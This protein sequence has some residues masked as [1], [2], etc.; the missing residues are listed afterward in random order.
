[1]TT[2]L[3]RD[4]WST[5]RAGRSLPPGK[6]RYLLYRRLGGPQGRGRQVRKISPPP[7][8]DP[9]T[10]QPAASR[11]NDYWP[12]QYHILNYEYLGPSQWVANSLK[13]PGHV[14]ACRNVNRE[15]ISIIRINRSMKCLKIII[16]LSWTCTHY[17]GVHFTPNSNSSGWKL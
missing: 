7:G 13:A 5:S 3:E 4:E 10:V 8:F 14:I 16:M 17:M 12:W 15:G 6:S 1:M 9:R 2:A 11:Y